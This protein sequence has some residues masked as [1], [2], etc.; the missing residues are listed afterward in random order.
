M[1]AL[2]LAVL[3]LAVACSSII[4]PPP[5]IADLEQT[6]RWAGAGGGGFDGVGTDRGYPD[7]YRDLEFC[8][9]T[10]SAQGTPSDADPRF[11]TAFMTCMTISGWY[12]QNWAYQ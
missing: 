8:N 12:Y 11:G 3:P 6:G 4:S 7:L 2:L 5:P 9:R 1:G 10:A